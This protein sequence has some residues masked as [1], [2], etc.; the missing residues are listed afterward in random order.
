MIKFL[1]HYFK[2]LK[3]YI[4]KFNLYSKK[5]VIFEIDDENI[6]LDKK[7]SL[8]EIT[9]ENIY[10]GIL[11]ISIPGNIIDKVINVMLITE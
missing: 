7:L 9:S 1:I 10:N 11:T 3:H 6:Y 4:H 5:I 8:N 2:D